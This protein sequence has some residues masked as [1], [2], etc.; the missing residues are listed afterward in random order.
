MKTPIDYA[1]FEI[2]LS[3]ISTMARPPARI[4]KKSPWKNP[5]IG[6]IQGESRIFG[7]IWVYIPVLP[8]AGAKITGGY[9]LAPETARHATKT[10]GV[11]CLYSPV[12]KRRYGPKNGQKRGIR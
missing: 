2:F 11:V 5:E 12:V 10:G 9:I 3:T 6:K 7:K 8:G 1:D 4:V